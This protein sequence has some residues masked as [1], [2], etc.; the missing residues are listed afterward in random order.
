MLPPIPL[1][2]GCISLALAS[3]GG[4][5]TTAAGFIDGIWVLGVLAAMCLL[6]IRSQKATGEKEA[7]TPINGHA[8]VT[9]EPPEWMKR[10]IVIGA[11]SSTLMQRKLR[12]N[13]AW[14]QMAYGLS[15]AEAE[16]AYREE[17][18]PQMASKLKDLGVTIV[19]LPLWSGVGSYEQEFPGM[20]DT[21]RFAESVHAN[22]MTVG[23]YIHNRCLSRE[24][25][26]ARP[27]CF[28]WLAWPSI[29]SNYT[30]LPP[31]LTE[32]EGHVV[33][34]NHPGYQAFIRGIIDYAVNEV[35]A[36]L[37]HF[38]NLVTE[39]GW[40]PLAIDNFRD[41]LRTKF[42]LVELKKYFGETDL[43][44]VGKDALAGVVPAAQEWQLFQGWSLADAFRSFAE[45]ARSLNPQVAVE[46]NA[47]GIIG[48]EYRR[49]IDLSLILP[50]GDAFWAEQTAQGW[51]AEEGTLRNNI[52]TLKLSR[53]FH[54]SAFTYTSSRLTRG[55]A[56][57]FNY[58]CL[59]CLYWFLYGKL[60]I[61]VSANRP[62][63][64]K[65]LPE[66]RFFLA[67]RDLFSQGETLAD[68]A[69]FRG[70][71]VNI[72]GPAEAVNNTALFEQALI[73]GHIP[74]EIIFDQH[75]DHLSG[76]RAVV[77]ADV[78]LMRDAHIDK[79]LRYAEAGGGLV[80][81]DQTASMNQWGQPIAGGLQRLFRMPVPESGEAFEGRGQGKVA[82][83][84]V[85]RPSNVVNGSLPVNGPHLVETVIKVMGP[86]TVCV[87]APVYV[88][89]EFV[90][91]P[92]R[93]LVHL[94]DYSQNPSLPPLQVNL[95]ASLGKVKRARLLTTGGPEVE[96]HTDP[97]AGGT[98]ITIPGLDIYGV[99]VID[100]E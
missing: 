48:H 77:L 78:R 63:E 88:G 19:L 4:E 100:M 37:L 11:N 87:N 82:L 16:A 61:A 79:L 2:V 94:V 25:L 9:H 56:L 98:E 24:F 10:G 93:V 81:T 5:T 60:N 27:E 38:D 17:M 72:N 99:V 71:D 50:N 32:S 58:N 8:N 65:M 39:T 59:G 83:T 86:P 15:D 68:V 89:A 62:A 74:F 3:H 1:A 54:Q 18:T 35:K 44:D 13:R 41:Y 40:G 31:P 92:G 85:M 70:R 76:Y 52:R 67:H 42:N 91:Q 64:A 26:E 73:T 36:D 45:Y 84:S 43:K 80:I 34:R 90:R 22:G 14:V 21:R 29:D 46:C 20:E 69:V 28:E 47:S 51:N 97:G 49:P 66:T 57:A 96:L 33:Y 12:I 95:S 23:V 30:V 75:L 53:L 55:E 6:S 7:R